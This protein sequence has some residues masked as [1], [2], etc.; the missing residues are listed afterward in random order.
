MCQSEKEY[1]NQII[2]FGE[3]IGQGMVKEYNKRLERVQQKAQQKIENAKSKS[4]IKIL[5][6]KAKAASI[7]GSKLG[8]YIPI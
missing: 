6:A 5:E 2:S 3:T 7:L 8:I 1:Q 4:L